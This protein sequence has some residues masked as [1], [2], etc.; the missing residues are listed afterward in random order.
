[1][2]SGGKQLRENVPKHEQGDACQCYGAKEYRKSPVG[3]VQ[4]KVHAPLLTA[5]QKEIVRER[6]SHSRCFANTNK[7]MLYDL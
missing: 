3:P 7:R 5:S 4:T 1:M 6:E 2:T